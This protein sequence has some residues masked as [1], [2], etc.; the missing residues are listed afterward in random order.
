[1]PPARLEFNQEERVDGMEAPQGARHA[2]PRTRPPG[3][4]GVTYRADPSRSRPMHEPSIRW[5]LLLG[6]GGAV[7]L[8]T[9][10][11]LGAHALGLG[12]AG[13]AA[14]VAVSVLVALAAAALL[15]GVFLGPLQRAWQER[16]ASLRREE[17]SRAILDTLLDIAPVGLAFLDA[18]LRCVRAN[19]ALAGMDGVPAAEHVG[20][21]L[22]EVLPRLGATL[23]P[24]LRRALE[25]GGPVLDA[26]IQ[27]E[28]A[29]APGEP[30]HWFGSYAP[31]RAG[32]RVLGVGAAWVEMTER[33]L[34]EHSLRESEDRLSVLTRSIPDYLWG[35]RSRGGVL[36]DFSCTPVIERMTGYDAVTF[37]TPGPDGAPPT[38]W[39]DMVHPEDRERYRALVLGLGPQSEA[40]LEHRILNAD[41]RVR[42]VRS[43]LAASA[44]DARGD[45]LLACV[46]SDITDRRLAD[47]LRQELAASFKRSALEWSETFDAV[48]SPLVVL[49]LEG[50][51]QR[52]NEAAHSL[53]D[54]GQDLSGQPLAAHASAQ[55]WR[56]ALALVEEVRQSRATLTRPV[57]DAASKRTWEV[58]AS[59]IQAPD[60]GGMRLILVAQE[61]TRLLE[62]QASVRRSET[63]A[64][65]GA[66]VAGVAHEVKNPL[67]SISA[68][69]D[70]LEA[71]LG[72]QAAQLKPFMDVLR[73]EVRRIDHLVQELFEY[74]R[75][76]RT[77]F[78]EGVLQDVLTDSVSACTLA[79]EKAGVALEVAPTEGPLP[80]RMDARRLFHAFRN[81]IE[82]AVQHSPAGS[83]VRLST[84]QVEEGGTR[85][86]CFTVRDAGPGFREEDLPHVF[87]PF[88]SRRRGGTGLGLSIVQR[89]VEEHRGTV[90]LGNHPEGGA[91]VTL[92][93]PLSS[94]PPHSP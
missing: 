92:R 56:G 7:A 26:S 81:V 76:T 80:V 72:A 77:D 33:M 93:L 58:A 66:L 18:E 75:P 16:A 34:A 1:M 30:H 52:M 19:A 87:E 12:A 5:R 9:L 4:D 43:H 82:N 6:L 8:A 51:I 22:A 71:T 89:I 24:R 49:D 32:G 94:P 53:L 84:G 88:Y 42:W 85:W 83:R 39:V 57:H 37:T 44:P 25:T 50:R 67:F 48:A 29:S 3:L 27:V 21:R 2:G 36:V 60:E 17:E 59:L 54:G 15:S 10:L 64:A 70:A 41:G 14:Q 38:L 90:L 65:L 47:D 69:A 45:L 61:V 73:G 68:V 74:G 86:A 55:P 62:L 28:S 13:L 11:G 35:C 46:V 31:V 79:S 20:R 91:Q 23:E 63:M 40:T 78:Q